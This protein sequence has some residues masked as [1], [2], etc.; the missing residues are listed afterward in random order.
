MQLLNF[1]INV[2][3]GILPIGSDVFISLPK[4]GRPCRAL[5]EHVG[6]QNQLGGVAGLLAERKVCE[7]AAL[8]MMML[9]ALQNGQ[10]YNVRICFFFF[11][12][13]RTSS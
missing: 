1:K 7:Q 11:L 4:A 3:T 2:A 5:A 12:Q 6:R 13:G 8:F 10:S 9:V